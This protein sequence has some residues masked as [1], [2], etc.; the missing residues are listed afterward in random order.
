MGLSNNRQGQIKMPM[1]S[2][3]YVTQRR[4][5]P[6]PLRALT[7]PQLHQ[8]LRLDLYDSIDFDQIG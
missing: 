5:D 7:T 2:S 4:L 8:Q 1:I 3:R 6:I